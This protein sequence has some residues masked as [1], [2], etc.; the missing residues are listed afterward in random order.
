MPRSW[1]GWAQ[2]HPSSEPLPANE[3]AAREAITDAFLRVY[4]P[5]STVEAAGPYID[6]PHDLQQAIDETNLKFAR[7]IQSIAVREV[8]F[9]S[10][11]QAAVLYDYGTNA[12]FPGRI[13][14]A[15]HVTG[16]WK[17][18]RAT[19]CHDFEQLAGVRCPS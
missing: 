9:T 6:D 2:S 16:Q 3:G 1:S 11:T 4:A 13:G 5:N 19:V 14:H 12:T 18:T 17:V 8:R 7:A 10:P 15:V